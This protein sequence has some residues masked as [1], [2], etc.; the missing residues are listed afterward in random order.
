MQNKIEELYSTVLVKLIEKLLNFVQK[1]PSAITKRQECSQT[2]IPR[3]TDH[4]LLVVFHP[5]NLE[6]SE[7]IRTFNCYKKRIWIFQQAQK[8]DGIT[9]VTWGWDHRNMVGDIVNNLINTFKRY[10]K[11]RPGFLEIRI[12]LY[13]ILNMQQTMAKKLSIKH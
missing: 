12:H 10:Y 13:F 6:E 11:Q 2:I 4:W 8:D 5:G 9:L 1:W 7:S 3:N